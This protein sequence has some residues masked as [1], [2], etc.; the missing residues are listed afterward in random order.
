MA[1]TRVFHNGKIYTVNKQQPWAEAIA[2]EGNK[3][4]FVGTNDE[5]L[6]L[7]DANTEVC[8]LSGKM[9]M[10]GFIDG[11]IHPLMSAAFASGAQLASCKTKE[12]IL[13]T[14]R[15]FVEANPDNETYFGQGFA[16]Y[17][18]A[19]TPALAD[20]LD[21]ICAD[22]PL[23]LVSSSCHGAWCNHKAFEVAGIDKNTPDITPGSNYF[24]R[25]E[26]GNPTGRCIESCY[27]QVAKGANYFPASKLIENIS[28][29][30]NEF[31]SMG[32]TTFC[33]CGVFSFV[34]DS[35]DQNF[36]DFLNSDEFV[37][38]LFG[39]YYLATNIHDLEGCLEGAASVADNLMNTDR[40]GFRYFKILGDGVIEARSAAMIK[41][42][43]NGVQAKPNFDSETAK[44]IGLLVAEAGYDLN[45]HAIGDATNAVALDMAE[46]VRDAGHDDTRIAISHSQC[47]APGAIE[48]AGKL[49]VFI[50]STG[51]W[52]YCSNEQY[53]EYFGVNIQGFTYPIK[54]L[55]N[56]G[57]KYGQGSDFPVADGKPDPFVSIEVGMRRRLVDDDSPEPADYC[58]APSLEESIESF[59]INNAWQVRM[60][61]KLGS[62]EV[63][64]LA[65]LVVV[66]KN[67]FD[68]PTE[69][70]HTCK[71]VETIRDGITT[72]KA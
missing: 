45:M 23:L 70:I 64:K 58:E 27:I 2:L 4:V 37:Q 39:G 16:D 46:A 36:V 21:A 1:A 62:I 28:T 43:D 63:G 55:I 34:V 41:P 19:S 6:K 31:A 26:E 20:D 66:D 40:V 7:A 71:V 67:L 9:M 32:Y 35:L 14:V 44:K 49:G 69:E 17:I 11:H 13:D 8:D 29:L 57:C 47:W 48:R 68:I 38:R 60:E 61:D 56:V 51:A 10:P 42:Y 18:F 72:Y 65:D 54:S 52:H 3:I 24:V 12:E 15:A 5:A 25:D 33:D 22:K 50:N 53:K 30:A 59:T